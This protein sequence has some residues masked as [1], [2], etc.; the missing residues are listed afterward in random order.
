MRAPRAD[1]SSRRWVY[2]TAQDLR[3]AARLLLKDRW[4]T[5]PA[6]LALAL[7][8]GMNGTMFTIVNAMTRGL[9]TVDPD[10]IMSI[11]AR[12]SAGQWRGLHV[13]Y[14]DFLDFRAATS[15]FSG[16]AA[17]SQSNMTL[18]DDGDTAE[19]WSAAYVSTNAFRLLDVKPA[20][21]L[22]FSAD[23]DQA[24]AAAV[25]ILGNRVWTSRY[26]SDPTAIGR[27]IRVSGVPATVI[28]VMP[29]GFRFPIVSDVWQPL[30]PRPGD[31]FLDGRATRLDPIGF[32]RRFGYV[33]EEPHLYPFLSGREYLELVGRLREMPSS[34]MARKIGALLEL[35]GLSQAAEQGIGSY[36]RGMKQKVLV[37]AALLQSGPA[38]FR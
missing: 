17:F 26:H 12:D 7:G 10:R 21:G 16:L 38:D 11:H 8:A 36:S 31:V 34:S 3:F 33:P 18:G 25:A 23:D 14:P 37:I 28:G 5:L 4:F 24:G 13:S 29:E 15:T 22:D 32:R 9:P 30:A 1:P 2:D 27:T 6:V 20:L 19:R 35:F